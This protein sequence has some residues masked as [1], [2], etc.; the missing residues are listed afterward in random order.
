MHPATTRSIPRRT[1]PNDALE[2]GSL[3]GDLAA[4]AEKSLAALYERLAS[5]LNPAERRR[6][7]GRVRRLRRRYRA[8][9]RDEIAHTVAQPQDVDEEIGCLFSIL[10]G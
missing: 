5:E 6:E 3:A 10:G 7:G 9:L 4:P 8:L 2:P 1:L